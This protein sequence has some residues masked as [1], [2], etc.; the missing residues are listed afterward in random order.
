MVAFRDY[1]LTLLPILFVL[2]PYGVKSNLRGKRRGILCELSKKLT[3][4][5]KAVYSVVAL[6]FLYITPFQVSISPD[7]L[8]MLVRSE[9]QLILLASLSQSALTL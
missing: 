8:L 1:A 6:S 3:Q 7:S 9:L 5:T 4:T 2:V